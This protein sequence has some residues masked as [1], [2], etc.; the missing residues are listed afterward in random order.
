MARRAAQALDRERWEGHPALLA[1]RRLGG[2][3]PS[4]IFVVKEELSSERRSLIY[5][6]EGVQRGEGAIIAKR[7]AARGIAVERRIYQEVLADLP[8][9]VLRCLGGV[10]DSDPRFAWLFLEAAG[11][12]D[13]DAD[14][15][16]HRAAAA[17]W[18][19]GL[20]MGTE[21]HRILPELPDRGP[22]HYLEHLHDGRRRIAECF[23]NP[24]LRDKDREL[25]DAIL[26]ALDVVESNW[27]AVDE[28][29]DG[30]PQVLVH[31]DF[32]ARNARVGGEGC[33]ARLWVFDWEVAGRGPPGI[34]LVRAD[35]ETYARAVRGR[36]PRLDV[37][38]QVRL[39][40]LLR[41]CL[42]PIGWET[43]ALDTPW[44]ERPL[45]GL[46]SYLRRL[47]DFLA[48]S[49]WSGGA[50]AQRPRMGGPA[51]TSEEPRQH[52]A[53]RAWRRLG[54]CDAGLV[55]V[56]A[57]RRKKVSQVYRLD[58]VGRAGSVIAKRTSFAIAA[59]ERC[60]YEQA[61][62]QLPVRRLALE[63]VLED[64]GGCWLFLE[65]AGDERAV[66]LEARRLLTTWLAGLHTSAAAHVGALPLPER[67]ASHHRERL[68]AAH[69]P[70]REHVGNPALA[71]ADRW[72]LCRLADDLARLDSR[73]H[74]VEA[75]CARM[76]R[77]LVHGDLAPSNLHRRSGPDGDEL[78]VLDWETAGIG[79]PAVDLVPVEP[80]LY[81][82]HVAEIWP[83]VTPESVARWQ[84]L[85]RLL[86][87][88][89]ATSW[90]S[91]ELAFPWVEK[92]MVRLRVYRRELEEAMAVLDTDAVA[93]G[94]SP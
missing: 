46:A 1:W 26:R 45:Y 59:I 83:G 69:R 89:V 94:V 43:L 14:S 76:P 88:V 10:P 53:A 56:E 40:Q 29:C 31:G 70:L 79:P 73:W 66:G 19:A 12:A 87:T 16:A 28:A 60:I 78:L 39:G 58:G 48:L 33:D 44:V 93:P 6:L 67:G 51:S 20:H 34:D 80:A 61:L 9:P 23:D 71:A 25:L 92:P 4:A 15:P 82:A 47:E 65:D 50:A 86:R 37:E 57:L 30:A 54:R 81:A 21:G 38:R 2:A 13:F 11:G 77:T 74:E 18:L 32:A 68:R 72:V 22:D 17:A 7:S 63:G 42:A 64:T 41:G 52:P 90:E 62:P 55:G 35:G 84:G 75:L 49:H 91:S 3:L 27:S 24:V 8:V 36:W 85:G 5:R